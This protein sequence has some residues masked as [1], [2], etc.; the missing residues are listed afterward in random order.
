MQKMSTFIQ[1]NL[2]QTY[3]KMKVTLAFFKNGLDSFRIHLCK[4]KTLKSTEC[5]AWWRTNYPNRSLLFDES[6]GF[7]PIRGLG[8]IPWSAITLSGTKV[9]GSK[10]FDVEIPQDAIC[11]FND[12]SSAIDFYER[13]IIGM[14]CGANSFGP[15]TIGLH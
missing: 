6:D 1:L 15:R 4:V 9:K 13:R 11:M 5:S 3:D 2:V 14:L 10:T 8:K 12:S 7:F